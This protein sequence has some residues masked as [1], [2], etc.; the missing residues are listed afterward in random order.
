MFNQHLNF[1][2]FHYKQKSK[3]TLLTRHELRFKSRNFSVFPEGHD[4][5]G[6]ALLYLIMSSGV[7]SRH[8]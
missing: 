7:W 4:H 6:T 3:K 5:H 2:E 1:I 8:G